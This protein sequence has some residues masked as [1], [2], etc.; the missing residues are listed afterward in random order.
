MQKRGAK[1]LYDT[2]FDIAT[3][4]SDDLSKQKSKEMGQWIIEVFAPNVKDDV[5]LKRLL[6]FQEKCCLLQGL[7]VS[8]PSQSG[9]SVST[10]SLYA[11]PWE[12]IEHGINSST[13]E[14]ASWWSDPTAVAD[15]NDTC[16][17]LSHFGARKIRPRRNTFD[18]LYEYGW[19]PSL[20]EN[21]MK[22]DENEP[23]VL[24]EKV[25]ENSKKRAADSLLEQN[26]K[27]K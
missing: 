3:V 1:K 8:N 16:I 4:L 23:F 12:F 2:L 7:K 22:V 10:E 20:G 17:S 13:G 11:R 15:L 27:K 9:D 6:P 14:V 21:K 19:R 25:I 24:P 5:R 26:V 18:V